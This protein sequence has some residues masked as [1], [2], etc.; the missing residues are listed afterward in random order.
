MAECS[1]PL[2]FLL[3][4]VIFGLCLVCKAHGHIQIIYN[5]KVFGALELPYST[6]LLSGLK[7]GKNTTYGASTHSVDLMVLRNQI[8]PASIFA[9]SAIHAPCPGLKR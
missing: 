6:K 9:I 8:E 1:P 3:K 4:F 2:E 7:R 5:L